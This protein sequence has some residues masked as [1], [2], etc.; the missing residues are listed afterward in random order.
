MDIGYWILDI[1]PF[2]PICEYQIP[3]IQY[4]KVRYFLNHYENVSPLHPPP[5]SKPE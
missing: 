3:N 1:F 2:P 5:F 4:Q